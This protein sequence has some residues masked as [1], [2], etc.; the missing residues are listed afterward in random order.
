MRRSLLAVGAL[1]LIGSAAAAQQDTVPRKPS[2]PPGPPAP[3]D[4]VPADTTRADTT[5]RDTV[6]RFLPIFAPAIARGPLPRGERRSFDADSL[7][8]SNITTLGDLLGHL[9]GVYVAR[10]GWFGAPEIAVYGG[11]GPMGLE[12]YWDGM[13]YLPL[14]RDSVWVDPARIPLAPLERVDIQV[15]PSTL[16]VFLVTARARSSVPRTGVQIST[17]V[18]SIAQYR[19]VFGKRWLSGIGLSL[20][21]DYRNID[22]IAGS[23]TTAFNMVDLW[24]RGELVKPRFGLSYQIV[25]SAWDRSAQDPIVQTWKQR[26]LDGIFQ[27]FLA[28]RDDGL[29]TRLTVG[30][31]R[32][33]ISNDSLVPDRNVWQGSVEL[34]E[35]RSRASASVTARFQGVERPFQVE[36]QAA[37]QPV[38]FF[39]LAVQGRRSQYGDK[40][41]GTRV[42]GSA[43]LA[44]PFGVSLR[45]EV[46]RIEDFQAPLV[47]ADSF[48][49]ATDVAGYARWGGERGFIFIEG[50][51]I[52]RDSFQPR[53]FAAGIHPVAGLGPTPRSRYASLSVS[54]RPVAGLQLSGWYFD[55]IRAGGDYEP[56]THGRFSA[57]FYSKFWRVYK[58]GAF[59]LRGEVAVESW[60]RSNLGGRDTAG[61]QLLLGPASFV[62]SNI[63]MRI[64]EFTAYWLTRN[65]NGMRGSYVPGLSYPKYAQYYGVQ[66]Y[67]RN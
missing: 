39:T 54:L 28:S 10:G 29:G 15:L 57:T 9:P 16:R 52:Q 11:K 35:T 62:E 37:W 22:G 56:P 48:Q 33:A 38:R 61:A 59:A 8:L 6:E 3:A 32:T 26:R 42:H 36:A 27:G 7:V 13:P 12:L 2:R 41:H 24:L 21:A 55:P 50:G 47:L 45:G 25:S 60:S 64:G 20:A 1:L 58:S 44:L 34:S 30:A 14:G 40:G 23:S 5:G 17:G 43:G 66:W 51:I 49:R 67:F 18:N 53:G 19:A 31:A 46:S 63:E 65:Y 4:T